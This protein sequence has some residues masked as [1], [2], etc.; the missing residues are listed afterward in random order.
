VGKNI[1]ALLGLCPVFKLTL[2]VIIAICAIALALI[3][4][5]DKLERSQA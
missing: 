2:I 4:A 5:W 3:C 1:L